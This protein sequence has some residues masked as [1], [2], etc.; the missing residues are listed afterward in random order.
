VAPVSML[1]T[2]V[3]S[4][5]PPDPIHQHFLPLALRPQGLEQNK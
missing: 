5:F 3:R 1:A 4:L 2:E